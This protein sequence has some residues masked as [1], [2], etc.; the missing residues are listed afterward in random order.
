MNKK[1]R[2][3][4]LL[5]IMLVANNSFAQQKTNPLKQSKELGKVHWYRK[6]DEA[7]TQAKKEQKDIVILFQEVPGCATCTNYAYNALSHPLMVE[8]LE[9]SF[10]PLAIF[11]NKNGKDIMKTCTF[12]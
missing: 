11:N 7:I 10:I 8:A 12:H 3:L 1:F 5:I 9:N 2:N 6:Y 4:V